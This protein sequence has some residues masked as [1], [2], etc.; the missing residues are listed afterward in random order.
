[1]D[2]PVT[3]SW[4]DF[5][6]QHA[7]YYLQNS[8]TKNTIVEVQFLVDVMELKG[9]MR[10]LDV[11]CG[12][13]RH[14]IELARRDIQVTGIDLSPGMLFE[15]QRDARAAGQTVEFIE[16][17]ATQWVA[18]EPFDAAICI[19]EGGLGLIGHDEDAV[20]HDLSILQ[21]VG[22]SLKPGAPFL[23]TALNGYASIRA[24]KDE[25]VEA[26]GFDPATM[27]SRYANTME[28]PEGPTTVHINERLFIPPEMTA[29][30]Y[31]A[32]FEVQ[33]VWGGTAGDWGKR[34]LKLDEIEAMYV[35]QKRA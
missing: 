5:F 4:R 7:P 8:F 29:M 28:L 30:L 19:C 12:V 25:D 2:G 10:L 18:P 35:C 14:A 23:M 13:G 31:H 1:M 22:K 11:G 21:N 24:M 9:G 17:D 6:D 34:P 27:V 32:G 15:A 20:Q 16:A 33:H 26:G 3:Q